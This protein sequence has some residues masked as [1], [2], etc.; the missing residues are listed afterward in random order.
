[1]CREKMVMLMGI[2]E[3][4]KIVKPRNHRK[5]DHLEKLLNY[6]VSIV[7]SCGDKFQQNRMKIRSKSNKPDKENCV[8]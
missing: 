1:M 5:K 6:F 3:S 8:D 7:S 2:M 4:N